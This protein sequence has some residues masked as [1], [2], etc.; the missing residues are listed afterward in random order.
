MRLC[1]RANVA[2]VLIGDVSSGGEKKNGMGWKLIAMK[3]RRQSKAFAY[4]TKAF[5]GFH[6]PRH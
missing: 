5:M 1:I 3:A 6:P 2:S 4:L